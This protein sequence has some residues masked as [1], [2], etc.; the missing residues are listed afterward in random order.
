[1]SEA[2]HSHSVSR[3]PSVAAFRTTP[4][5]LADVIQ[6]AASRSISPSELMRT[7][8]RNEVERSHA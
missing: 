4:Q 1:M 6:L 2:S 5:L 3:L 8:V 7:A